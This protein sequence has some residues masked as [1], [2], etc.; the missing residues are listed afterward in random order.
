M[1]LTT[2]RLIC[3]NLV[4]VLL[5]SLAP[6][7]VAAAG[8][9][10]E[11]ITITAPTGEH[12]AVEVGTIQIGDVTVPETTS[13]QGWS[14]AGGV[15]T[16][17][18]DYPGT[19]IQAS[20]G[21]ILAV[22]GAVTVR[23]SGDAAIATG[24]TL[25]CKAQTVAG[26]SLTVEGSG[27]GAAVT[28]KNNAYAEYPFTLQISNCTKAMNLYSN[29][30]YYSFYYSLSDSSFTNNRCPQHESTIDPSSPVDLERYRCISSF[31]SGLSLVPD[32]A[33]KF[34]FT[35]K[36]D[37]QDGTL[38]GLSAGEVLVSQRTFPEM[39]QVS[40]E[41]V[42]FP[43]KLPAPVRDG[44]VF[45][46]WSTSASGSYG[47]GYLQA[48]DQA[49][50]TKTTGI[51]LYA[52]W[53]SAPAG[54]FVYLDGNG[55]SFY[56]PENS[57]RYRHAVA[58]TDGK[59]TLPD[60]HNDTFLG[61]SM[62]RREKVDFEDGNTEMVEDLF[63]P[64]ET[65]SLQPG[66]VLYAVFSE[67]T[68]ANIH[69]NGYITASGREQIAVP[70]RYVG[71]VSTETLVIYASQL[72]E[73]G[74]FQSD[75]QAVLDFNST[76]DGSGDSLP[77]ARD[78]AYAQ[79]T[80]AGQ[81]TILLYS[82][83]VPDQY[84][85]YGKV[86]PADFSLDNACGYAWPGHRFLGW[87]LADDNAVLT[88]LH[89]PDENG[90]ILLLC[91]WEPYQVTLD[92]AQKVLSA[93]SDGT[94]QLPPA[95]QDGLN[96]VYFNGWNTREDGSG[97]WYFPGQRFT[98]VEDLVLYPQTLTITS[99]DAC[100][101]LKD[102]GKAPVYTRL[103]GT[104]MDSSMVQV[105]LP[106]T[107]PYWTM[108]R[109]TSTVREVLGFDAGVSVQ[110]PQGCVLSVSDGRLP[111]TTIYSDESSSFRYGSSFRSV[112]YSPV[113]TSDLKTY[114]TAGDFQTKPEGA[115]LQAWITTPQVTEESRLYQPGAKVNSWNGD[116]PKVLYP[117]WDTVD[118]VYVTFS[119]QGNTSQRLYTAGS[120]VTLPVPER[121]GYTF[122]GWS[123]GTTLYAPGDSYTV[124]ATEVTL[125]AQ[126]K[127]RTMLMVNGMEYATGTALDYPAE[128][129]KWDGNRTL[130]LSGYHGGGIFLPVNSAQIRFEGENT[131]TAGEGE[132]AIVCTSRLTIRSDAG[133]SAS[134][135]VT[136]GSGAPAVFTEDHTTI[137]SGH[138]LLQGGEGAAAWKGNSSW[139][140]IHVNSDQYFCFA[141]AST[142]ELTELKDSSE[143]QGQSVLCTRP[144]FATLTLDA[145][146]G[147][148]H[149]R[150]LWCITVEKGMSID[151]RKE[152]PVSQNAQFLCWADSQG[153]E[154]SRFYAQEDQTVTAR[155]ETCPYERYLLLDCQWSGT[156]QGKT[157]LYV[158]LP[159]D[160]MVTLPEMMPG[161]EQQVF[162]NWWVELDDGRHMNVP[163]GYL[164]DVSLFDPGMT[165]RPNMVT[166]SSTNRYIYYSFN[167][168]VSVAEQG[169]QGSNNPTVQAWYGRQNAEGRVI[170]H[171][172]EKPDG[173]G[174]TWNIGD[175]YEFSEG[176]YGVVLYAQWKDI[177]TMTTTTTNEKLPSWNSEIGAY[178]YSGDNYLSSLLGWRTEDGKR[179]YRAGEACNLPAGTTLYAFCGDMDRACLIVLDGNGAT[180][181]CPLLTSQMTYQNLE[182]SDNLMNEYVTLERSRFHRE[183]YVLTGWNTR[184]DGSGVSY[185]TDQRFHVGIV[186]NNNRENN[187]YFQ[188]VIDSLPR[189]LYAQWERLPDAVIPVPQDMVE[190][191]NALVYLALYRE[192]GAFLGVQTVTADEYLSLTDGKGASTYRFFC[193]SSDDSTRP[194][195]TSEEGKLK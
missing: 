185:A 178:C 118:C 108:W 173:S 150:S 46:G 84:G 182:G 187:Q 163:A 179:F 160:G 91:Q 111:D 60:M 147:K 141:G 86:A 104:F 180:D 11:T 61:W 90:L 129:W 92:G 154:V 98:P 145:G 102:A 67:Q 142:A 195:T 58:L 56:L 121:L 134:L 136:G 138:V 175:T 164:V 23:S 53:Q 69:G 140:R 114:P 83:T 131:V 127:Q 41:T 25:Y 165:L 6:M 7:P 34:Q 73:A 162:L 151:I 139:T 171:W 130:T 59:L 63:F 36:L 93:D 170:S 3:L 8:T 155:W 32:D 186:D 146:E 190:Q 161:N 152:I 113:S 191:E 45:L 17:T 87:S 71:D 126:W 12:I 194:L 44:Y 159:E 148:I 167:G 21:L 158:E 188:D 99:E 107:A 116:I 169:L 39:E 176:Q 117:L 110:L 66:A 125:T 74:W 47:G 28:G 68:A 193:I 119:D 77:Y 88:D 35:L 18:A 115:S 5:L 105:T 57:T 172:N 100:V 109:T 33:G 76:P 128:G 189:T 123:D 48:G 22:E 30:Q 37:P 82:H 177:L 19:P 4:L 112:C 97:V 156:V 52:I 101:L 181:P 9:A 51:T 29:Y 168:V 103:D 26:S 1:N 75:G 2:R 94:V 16:L 62:E 31:G 106:D 80:D 192:D 20:H 64:G 153:N 40:R 24:G 95:Q 49:Q 50:V 14:Y 133:T 13:G 72:Q 144:Q 15:L 157:K 38:A 65:V 135:T 124:P 55:E 89:Q 42:R 184:P 137:Q 85:R 96:G 132:A 143:Y 81:N 183:G 70:A 27:T 78:I 79:W 120:E 122:L 149:G 10:T 54:E 174:R 166:S 43:D